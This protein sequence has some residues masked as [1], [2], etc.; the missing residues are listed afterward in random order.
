[1]TSRHKASWLPGD[2]PDLR[3]PVIGALDSASVKYLDELPAP[4]NYGEM[5]ELR[6]AGG[7]VVLD[8]R[9]AD[10]LEQLAE[11]LSDAGMAAKVN[12]QPDN[13]TKAIDIQVGLNPK[14]GH[15]H[16]LHAKQSKRE[17]SHLGHE[18]L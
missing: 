1:M 15:D 6:H 18:E 10:A 8:D 7:T 11:A 3:I 17:G 13:K 9:V 5:K 16:V 14:S 12:I 2:S 4:V